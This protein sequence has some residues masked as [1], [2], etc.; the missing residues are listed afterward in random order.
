MQLAIFRNNTS[1]IQGESFVQ[2]NDRDLALDID[3]I[4]SFLFMGREK[5]SGAPQKTTGKTQRGQ[6][7]QKKFLGRRCRPSRRSFDNLEKFSD[8][9]VLLL[10]RFYMA[11]GAERLCRGVLPIALASSRGTGTDISNRRYP[12]AQSGWGLQ[13]LQRRS[14]NHPIRS[15]PARADS[16]CSLV[17]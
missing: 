15:G 8:D 14:S 9:S 5:P 12:S 6:Q 4:T 1:R 7:Y 10:G 11:A 2:G 13:A 17:K 16:T 3:R